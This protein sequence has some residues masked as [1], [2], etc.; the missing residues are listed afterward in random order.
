MRAVA[1]RPI[2]QATRATGLL[3]TFNRAGVLAVPDVQ[4]AQRVSWLARETDESVQ[5]A[6]ALV[7]RA[8]RSGSV[9]VAVAS[10]EAD[11]LASLEDDPP[12][13]LPWPNPTTWASAVEQSP[14][15]TLGGEALGARPLRLVDGLLYLERSFEQQE[16]VRHGLLERARIAHAYDPGSLTEQASRLFP[17]TNP[18]TDGD[19]LPRRAAEQAVRSAVTVIAGGPGTGK[20]TTIARVLALISLQA[21]RP[22]RVSLAAPSGKAAARLQE[23][24]RGEVA[25]L[26]LP[27]PIQDRLASVTGTTLH[28]LLGAAPGRRPKRTANHPIPADVVVVDETS[29]VS[30]QKMAELIEAVRPD[31]RLILVGD[32]DQLASIDAGAVLADITAAVDAGRIGVPLVRLTRSWRYDGAI[33]ELAAALRVGDPDAIPDLLD[34]DDG[35]VRFLPLDDS[36]LLSSADMAWLQN[37]V[38]APSAVAVQA[39]LSGDPGAAICAL[40]RHRILCAHRSGLHSKDDWNRRLEQWLAKQVPGFEIDGDHYAGQP[41]MVTSNDPDLGIYNGDSGIV[42]ASAQGLQVALDQGAEPK[43]LVPALLEHLETV[44]AMTIHKAQG[45]QFDDVTVILPMPGSPLL[46]RQL[47]YTGVTRAKKQVTLVAHPL[48]LREAVLRQAL[49]ASGLRS[50]L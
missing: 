42:V 20:T 38:T 11:V 50:R 32:P 22:I 39:A 3:R 31:A 35:S 14:L 21:R 48:A 26:D 13:D 7:I 12:A 1:G 37:R 34:P 27:R 9:C 15:V 17:V 33:Q 2:E 23:A 47:L 36:G 16:I 18:R 4:V 5:L 25:K 45:S 49:R 43:L 30:L 10:M 19:D 29:M 8:L 24:V 44:H 28:T 46:T 40:R 6:F 41:V